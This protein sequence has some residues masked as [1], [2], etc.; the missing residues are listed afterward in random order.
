M[1]VSS[2]GLLQRAEQGLWSGSAFPDRREVETNVAF[3]GYCSREY[4]GAK[5]QEGSRDGS[6]PP[7]SRDK[8][9]G[10]TDRAAEDEWARQL[11]AQRTSEC[12][13]GECT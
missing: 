6:F 4:Q 3:R 5:C 1:E 13:K 9:T 8:G 11:C 10:T 7:L 12:G 2:S